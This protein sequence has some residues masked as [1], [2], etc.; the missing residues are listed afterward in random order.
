MKETEYIMKINEFEIKET[1][2]LVDTEYT[3]YEI[4]TTIGEINIF[5]KVILERYKEKPNN[6]LLI[7]YITGC[8]ELDEDY[9]P[10]DMEILIFGTPEIKDNCIYCKFEILSNRY[11]ELNDEYDSIT[12]GE[13]V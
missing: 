5:E 13:L 4:L 2:S 7:E 1:E 9:F 6:L 8:V 12:Y 10:E 11:I 3:T